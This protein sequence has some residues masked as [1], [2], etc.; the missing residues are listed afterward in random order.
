MRL[1]TRR[2]AEQVGNVIEAKFDERDKMRTQTLE[3]KQ[4]ALAMENEETRKRTAKRM[5]ERQAAEA[6]KRAETTEQWEAQW[7]EHAGRAQKI[8]EMQEG[9]LRQRQ[10]RSFQAAEEADRRRYEAHQLVLEQK[11]KAF[12][13]RAADKQL[14]SQEQYEKAVHEKRL[15]NELGKLKFATKRVLVSAAACVLHSFLLFA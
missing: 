8:K 11:L 5:A 7:V 9:E 6:A 1:L 10:L 15:K 2:I 4:A 13:Q 12:E 14:R 3:L